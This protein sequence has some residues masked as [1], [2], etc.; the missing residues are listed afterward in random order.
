MWNQNISLG[1]LQGW[2]II[3]ECFKCHLHR[4]EAYKKAP[5]ARI[6][7]FRKNTTT[8]CYSLNFLSFAL[9]DSAILLRE[10][11]ASNPNLLHL[12]QLVLS[13]FVF[14]L[15]WWTVQDQWRN[16]KMPSPNL[17]KPRTTWWNPNKQCKMN[18]DIW[19]AIPHSRPANLVNLKEHWAGD[20][21]ATYT[22]TANTSHLLHQPQ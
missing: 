13:L 5:V 22:A 4:V 21:P 15:Q 3:Q 1:P 7:Q 18:W 17:Q 12:Y 9:I 8:S 14:S 11:L 16:L 2:L 19:I 6:M 10:D 20:I